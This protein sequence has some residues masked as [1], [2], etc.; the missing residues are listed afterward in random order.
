[1]LLKDFKRMIN[2]GCEEIDGGIAS[3]GEI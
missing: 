3:I 1:M 2:E